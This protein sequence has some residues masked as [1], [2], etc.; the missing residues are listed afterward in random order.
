MIE[1]TAE[2]INPKEIAGIHIST[3]PAKSRAHQIWQQFML[4]CKELEGLED[5]VYYSIQEYPA[6]YP[7]EVYDPTA[8]FT[9]WA[10][11]EVSKNCV[12]PNGFSQTEIKGGLYAHFIHKGT[13]A[14]ISDSMIYFHAQWLPKSGY[15][16]DKTRMHFERLDRAFLGPE[17]PDSEEDVY[18]PVIPN[19]K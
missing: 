15:M 10:A 7:W 6:D 13:S 12:L 11:R 18:I 8:Q 17:N 1:I 16:I 14:S 4:R 3:S 5:D 19:S 9:T 2:N